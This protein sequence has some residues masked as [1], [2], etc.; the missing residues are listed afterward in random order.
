M[1][2]SMPA[3]VAYAAMAAPALPLVGMARRRMPSSFAMETAMTSPRALKEPVGR[4][5]SSLM[6][7]DRPEAACEFAALDERRADF[8]EGDDV[9]GVADWQEFAVSPEVFGAGGEVGFGD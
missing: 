8:A 5:P 7:S 1:K 2:D 4:R 6:V 3:R 9:R